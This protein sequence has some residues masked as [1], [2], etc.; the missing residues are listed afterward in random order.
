MNIYLIKRVDYTD[1]DEMAAMVIAAESEA[2]AQEL[3]RFDG[4]ATTTQ[5]IGIAAPG[6]SGVVCEDFMNG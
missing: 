3:A 5:L 1:W 2:Q 6:V 4:A